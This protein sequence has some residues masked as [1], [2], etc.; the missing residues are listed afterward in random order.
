MIRITPRD[1]PWINCHLKTMLNRKNRF[2]K[3][4]K[5]NGYQAADK[6]R[7]GNFRQDYQD[8][9]EQAKFNYIKNSG[10]KLADR[11]TS[12]RSYWKIYNRVTDK[13]KTPKIPPLLVNNT[14][15]IDFKEKAKLFT[16][17]FTVNVYQMTVFYQILNIPQMVE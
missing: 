8:A 5:R 12:Q 17:F 6:I 9:V 2:F 11:N 13:C 15:I 4:F 3:N 14:F 10:N 7:L 16:P 1:P